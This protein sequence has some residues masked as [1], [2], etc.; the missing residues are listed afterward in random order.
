MA[1][2]STDLYMLLR[3]I[4]QPGRIIIGYFQ[5]VTQIGLVLNLNYPHFMQQILEFL[6][7]LAVDL[8]IVELDCMT[9]G[10][11]D[12]YDKWVVKVLVLP[13]VLLLGVGISVLLRGG[14]GK[15]L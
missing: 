14:Y 7:V 2:R 13:A 10:K 9:G 1:Q 8:Q 3:I 12:F 5:V 4:Y 6:K 11:L 15:L